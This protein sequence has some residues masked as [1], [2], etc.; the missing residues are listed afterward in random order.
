[1]AGHFSGD[2]PILMENY[3]FWPI[4]TSLLSS[5][6]LLDVAVNPWLSTI[7]ILNIFEGTYLSN[8][9]SNSLRI[10]ILKKS[11]GVSLQ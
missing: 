4:I 11:V 6:Q 1:M 2:R 3:L 10:L 5:A 7:A 9:L 8:R